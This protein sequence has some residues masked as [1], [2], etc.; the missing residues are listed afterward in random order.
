VNNFSHTAK[1]AVL[2]WGAVAFL[3]AMDTRLR[4]HYQTLKAE[5]RYR[6]PL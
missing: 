3:V 2:L 5:G 6:Q 4:P 1:I